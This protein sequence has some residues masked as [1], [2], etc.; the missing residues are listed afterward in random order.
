MGLGAYQIAFSEKTAAAAR[1]RIKEAGLG[2]RISCK[3][4]KVEAL[5]FGEASFELV[6][7][8]GPMLLKGDRQKKMNELYRVLRPG[9]AALLGGRFL[10]IPEDRRTPSEALRS[11]AAATGIE[12]IKIIDDM[13]QWVEFRKGIM[14]QKA[15]D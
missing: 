2:H 6:T 8:T 14:E 3:V 12:S 7:G 5:P 4:G 15:T 1:E 10:G 9:G 13:G 11:D